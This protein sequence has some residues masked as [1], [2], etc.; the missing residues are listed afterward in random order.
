MTVYGHSTYVGLEL[1]LKA[2]ELAKIRIKK[3]LRSDT[4]YNLTST[5]ITQLTSYE[6]IAAINSLIPND[7]GSIG[8]CIKGQSIINIVTPNTNNYNAAS[9]DIIL[10][11]NG[12]SPNGIIDQNY[13]FT[14]NLSGANNNNWQ[15]T[16][17]LSILRWAPNTF[18]VLTSKAYMLALTNNSD[19]NTDG[20][21]YYIPQSC[22]AAVSDG[23]IADRVVYSLNGYDYTGTFAAN[24]TGGNQTSH[25]YSLIITSASSANGWTDGPP[26]RPAAQ[27]KA[28]QAY[29][30]Y[31]GAL[32]VKDASAASASNTLDTALSG[33]NG[34]LAG[35]SALNAPSTW[36]L[37][38]CLYNYNMAVTCLM[39]A[40]DISNTLSPWIVQDSINAPYAF[41]YILSLAYLYNKASIFNGQA[42]HD[43]PLIN[44]LIT[45]LSG[46][47]AN[48][49]LNNTGLPNVIDVNYTLTKYQLLYSYSNLDFTRAVTPYEYASL[50][51]TLTNIN[52]Y[53]SGVPLVIFKSP[54]L[55]GLLDL[56]VMSFDDINADLTSSNQYTGQ[57]GFKNWATMMPVSV[58]QNPSTSAYYPNTTNFI[59][60]ASFGKVSA[61]H[62]LLTDPTSADTVTLEP[63][64]FSTF[65]NQLQ[66]GTLLGLGTVNFQQLLSIPQG[67]NGLGIYGDGV[68]ADDTE[69]NFTTYFSRGS[70]SYGMLASGIPIN[71]FCAGYTATECITNTSALS[72]THN[73]GPTYATEYNDTFTCGTSL[74]LSD[75]VTSDALYYWQSPYLLLQDL[76]SAV[77][78]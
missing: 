56:G 44:A 5:E 51:Q 7:S 22:G 14:A 27:V 68:N 46:A 2:L 54:F 23:N 11:Y 52:A 20:I 71:A 35:G 76:M 12:G 26:G 3:I 63:S 37:L 16:G 75:L 25:P 32:A 17:L 29:V 38:Q 50:N 49:A 13:S 66:W 8:N 18:A 58:T 70:Y 4:N 72:V 9:P 15:T 10:N 61:W 69:S 34:S 39:N 36:N 60:G 62:A 57:Q 74:E 59:S 30:N 31:L 77:C 64:W 6:A 24:T 78:I 1:P 55:L 73:T 19:F 40:S 67:S 42:T 28:L 41:T 45:D 47:N 53:G 65:A 21:N 33:S 48:N 43:N